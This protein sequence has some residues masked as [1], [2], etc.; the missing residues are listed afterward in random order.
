M[1]GS[2]EDCRGERAL[3]ESKNQGLETKFLSEGVGDVDLIDV[4]S[5]RL[6]VRPERVDSGLGFARGVCA[7]RGVSRLVHRCTPDG[8]HF[9]SLFQGVE[10]WLGVST[11]SMFV[12][13]MSAVPVCDEG[14]VE[15]HRRKLSVL[16]VECHARGRL[17]HASRPL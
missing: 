7:R 8:R 17:A 4:G 6:Q 13:S 15:H 11:G 14:G 3:E 5:T 9:K 1:L 12:L 10:P 16:R 2:S